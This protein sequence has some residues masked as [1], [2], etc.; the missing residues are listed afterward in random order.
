[1]SSSNFEDDLVSG[2][3]NLPTTELQVDAVVD[4]APPP[5]NPQKWWLCPRRHCLQCIP[6]LS[7]VSAR[8]CALCIAREIGVESEQHG[9]IYDEQVGTVSSSVFTRRH[10]DHRVELDWT[11]YMASVTAPDTGAVVDRMMFHPDEQLLEHCRP[12]LDPF[13][14]FSGQLASLD[15]NHFAV[16]T[17]TFRAGE[18]ATEVVRIPKHPLTFVLERTGAFLQLSNAP[19]SGTMPSS[20]TVPVARTALPPRRPAAPPPEAGA[21]TKR[22]RGRAPAGKSWDPVIGWVPQIH[23][24]VEACAPLRDAMLIAPSSDP[25]SLVGSQFSNPEFYSVVLNNVSSYEALLDTLKNDVGPHEF[26]LRYGNTADSVFDESA[27]ASLRASGGEHPLTLWPAAADITQALAMQLR[28]AAIRRREEPETAPEPTGSGV[29]GVSGVS[30]AAASSSYDLPRDRAAVSDGEDSEDEVDESALVDDDEDDEDDRGPIDFTLLRRDPDLSARHGL[31]SDIWWPNSFDLENEVDQKRLITIY[32]N[33]YQLQVVLQTDH[34]EHHDLRF[35]QSH[36]AREYDCHL[37]AADDAADEEDDAPVR[38][39]VAQQKAS[40]QQRYKLREARARRAV[41]RTDTM[42]R[43]KR[44]RT[45]ARAGAAAAAAAAAAAPAAAAAAAAPRPLTAKQKLALERNQHYKRLDW[46]ED[47]PRSGVLALKDGRPITLDMFRTHNPRLHAWI[48][49]KT[50]YYDTL[51]ETDSTTL[52]GFKYRTFEDGTVHP[53]FHYVNHAPSSGRPN[54]LGAYTVMMTTDS[55][56]TT[57]ARVI[58]PELGALLYAVGQLD[59]RLQY[60]AS[61]HSWVRYMIKDPPSLA[62]ERAERWIK[63]A[64]AHNADF[65]LD[66]PKSSGAGRKARA[67]AVPATLPSFDFDSDINAP[68]FDQPLGPD[69]SADTADTDRMTEMM[70]SQLGDMSQLAN[71]ELG[72]LDLEAFT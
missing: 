50:A 56:P 30:G 11:T 12:H 67:K 17:A 31:P 72:E 44:P 7:N 54:H 37:Q 46:K 9:L 53:V 57:I 49:D 21:G 18:V 52:D 1:M 28:D 23:F 62:A 70:M 4:Q 38:L 68:I 63:D 60:S 43:A 3:M 64:E 22:P 34:G 10:L 51:H 36:P 16:R 47:N 48:N 25:F 65:G 66:K 13:G 19:R 71:H 58:D 32:K 5:E 6:I 59:P 41:G 69:T 45:E 14:V 40:R 42:R 26:V 35:L 15:P 55:G 27:F 20:T 39:T 33:N 8:N 29:S 61:V 2:F 24:R